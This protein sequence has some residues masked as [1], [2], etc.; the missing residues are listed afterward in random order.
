MSEKVGKLC[1]KAIHKKLLCGPIFL[2]SW[3]I[4]ETACSNTEWP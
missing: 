3:W 4:S 1:E 2:Q